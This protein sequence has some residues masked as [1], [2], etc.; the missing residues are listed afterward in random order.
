MDE[1]IWDKKLINIKKN[2]EVNDDFG[3]DGWNRMQGEKPTTLDAL[4][5]A[6]ITAMSPKFSSHLVK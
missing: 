1:Y 5:I 4:G 6:L 2:M 3:I